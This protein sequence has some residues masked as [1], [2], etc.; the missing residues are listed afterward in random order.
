MDNGALKNEK[1]GS[2]WQ[3]SRFEQ[4]LEHCARAQP[5]SLAVG[6]KV[7]NRQRLLYQA[8]PVTPYSKYP[9]KIKSDL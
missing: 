8:I 7:N 9:G 6:L 1:R 2:E 4:I 3:M 5:A